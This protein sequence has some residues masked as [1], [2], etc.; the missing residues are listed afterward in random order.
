M[1]GRHR[2]QAGRAVVVSGLVDSSG[3]PQGWK[4]YVFEFGGLQHRSG[5]EAVGDSIGAA[6][7][8]Y[9]RWSLITQA[10]AW[11]LASR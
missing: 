10:R 5:A 1:A 8:K 11:L 2:I 9:T 6:D 4:H 3:L 7:E